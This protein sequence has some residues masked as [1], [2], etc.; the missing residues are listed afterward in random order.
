MSKRHR[1]VKAEKLDETTVGTFIDIYLAQSRHDIVSPNVK[2]LWNKQRE[3]K[4]RL[5]QA[6]QD[7]RPKT[8][9]QM[10]L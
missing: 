3:Q 8:D 6:L 1:R 5:A 10:L 9:L 7:N 4:E 2:A